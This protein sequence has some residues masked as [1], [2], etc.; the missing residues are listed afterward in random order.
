MTIGIDILAMVQHFLGWYCDGYHPARARWARRACALRALGL[1]LADGALTVERGKTR[2]LVLFT[3]AAETPVR[4]VKKSYLRW[5]MYGLSEGYK[6]AV[7][8]NWGCMAK[9]G[10]FGQKWRFWA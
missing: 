8:Q 10:F 5:E 2:K 6:Q 1:L 7:D 4:K 3:K 9:I